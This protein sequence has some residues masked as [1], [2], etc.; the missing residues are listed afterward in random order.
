[1]LLDI[2]EI[3]DG[4]DVALDIL[5]MHFYRDG[6]DQR[7]R[8][9]GLIEVGRSLLRRADYTKKH[10]LRDFGMNT[11]ILMCCSGSDGEATLRDIC[12]RVRAGLET[13]YLSSHDLSYVLKALFETHPLV[14]LDEFLLPELKSKNRRLFDSDFGFG[15][16]VEDLSADILLQWAAVDSDLRFPLL[17]HSISMFKRQPGEEGNTVTPLFL[18]I[19][20]HAPDK[21]AFLGDV[22]SKLHPKS[23]SGSLADI[24]EY[25]RAAILELGK[26]IGGDV[27][28]RV[29]D[30]LPELDRWIEQARTRDRN[31]E[32]SFE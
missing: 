19:L 13:V 18:E 6:K 23:W 5:H 21:R 29:S 1:M 28:R 22:G 4:V 30:L 7:P 24:L 20:E 15:T 27:Q 12:A 10:S 17:G 16:P 11:V 14:A 31:N 9:P 8:S 3:P 25:R 26:K 2:A 32:Q